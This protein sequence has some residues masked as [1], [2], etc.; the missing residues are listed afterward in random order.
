LAAFHEEILFRGYLLQNLLDLR[1]PIFGVLFTSV[2]FWLVHG[3]NPAAWSSPFVAINLMLA[4]VL[5]ALAYLIS[6]NIWF[7]TA[8]H[9]AWN[10]F[11]GP[12]L[13]IPVSGLTMQGLVDLRVNPDAHP[14]LTG[15]AFGLE[16]SAVCAGV[17]VIV[18]AILSLVYHGRQMP[19]DSEPARIADGV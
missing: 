12:I 17:Q 4:G 2:L 10:Y 9:F 13:S 7:P 6:D 3:L 11:Q 5:L 1:R 14:Y 16:G 15:G 19:T 18:I 8:M